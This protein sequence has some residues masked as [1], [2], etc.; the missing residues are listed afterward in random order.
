MKTRVIFVMSNL[1][2]GGAQK[3][4]ISL[5]SIFNYQKYE[6]DLLLFQPGGSLIPQVPKEVNILYLDDKSSLYFKSTKEII[7]KNLYKLRLLPIKDILKI[8]FKKVLRVSNGH[9]SQFRWEAIGK[10]LS[11]IEK[12]YDV[13]IGYLQSS[14]VYYVVDKIHANKK[15]AWFHSD[16]KAGG[17]NRELDKKYYNQVEKVIS[18]SDSAKQVL[19]DVF[20]DMTDKFEVV[21]N[22]IP[23]S[24]IKQL[25]NERNPFKNNNKIKI[26]SLGRIDYVKGYDLQISVA[27]RMAKDGYDF[28]WYVI[29]GGNN[30]SLY[31]KEIKNYNLEKYFCFLGPKNNPYPYLK[32]CDIYVQTSRYESYCIAVG[33]AKFFNKPI[34][35]TNFTGISEQLINE[36]TGL[37]VDINEDAI[38]KGVTRMIIDEELRE[39]I[40][41]NLS[42]LES[43]NNDSMSKLYNLIDKQE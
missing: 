33:E 13:A 23:Y 31:L 30:L 3:S 4:L 14:P 29:G 34:V 43:S 21:H 1:D 41:V 28:K 18:V 8:N 38:Y 39:S 16:Y 12:Q 7:L 19:K 11:P 42:K 35:S 20:N 10:Y 32:F 17:Y 5:L 24:T 25:A 2:L 6:V 37:I 26:V 15:I 27:K 36:K 40:Q 9:G 22:I